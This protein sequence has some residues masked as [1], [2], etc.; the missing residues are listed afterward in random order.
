MV[1]RLWTTELVALHVFDA[2][3]GVGSMIL[4]ADHGVDFCKTSEHL[5]ARV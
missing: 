5:L 4:S 2:G 1:A 3:I